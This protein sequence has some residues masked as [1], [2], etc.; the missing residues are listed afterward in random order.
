MRVDGANLRIRPLPEPQKS[1]NDVTDL[2]FLACRYD[3]ALFIIGHGNNVESVLPEQVRGLA[4]GNK[5]IMLDGR[6]RF[7][8]DVIDLCPRDQMQYVQ[9]PPRTQYAM[10]LSCDSRV[11]PK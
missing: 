8:M 11:V 5:M 10:E 4:G 1:R 9:I 3:V 7:F 6:M 2:S